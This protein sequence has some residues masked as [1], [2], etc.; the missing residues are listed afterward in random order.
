MKEMPAPVPL[1]FLL[2]ELTTRW[3]QVLDRRF[4]P[5][6]L[7]DA[8]W[9][10][11]FHLQKHCDGKPQR[12][13][14][15]SMGIEGASV[16]WLLDQL[17]ASGLVERREAPGDRRAKNVHLTEKGHELLAVIGPVAAQVRA[18]AIGGV[19]EVQLE[20]CAAVLRQMLDNLTRLRDS[21]A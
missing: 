3:R 1:G 18:E 4:R 8:Q 7:S 20:E 16:V 9:R 13:L 14:A 2:H 5:L 21:E 17:A 12:V 11:L 15:E 19:D 10:A 6:G